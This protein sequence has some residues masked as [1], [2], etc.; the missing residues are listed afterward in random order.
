MEDL[1]Q[2]AHTLFDERPPPS[3]PVPSLDVAGTTS[4][5]TYSSLLSPELP[6]PAEVEAMG[7]TTRHRPGL[8]GGIPTSTQSSFS[9]SPSDAAMESRLTP[10]P[11]P[12]LSPL[13]PSSKTLAEGVETTMQEQVIP[14]AR[15]TKAVET[16]PHST[17]PEVVPVS[18][19]SVAEWRLRQSQL[20]PHP[21]APRIP[22]SPPE[23]VLS[24]TSE[25]PLSSATSLQTA[26]RPF[27]T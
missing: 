9:S 24:S 11:T 8:I 19:T 22:Q 6:Q 13:I 10:S 5:Y 2:N 4:T 18:P 12:L 1:I 16:L 21:E 17:P 3:P 15:G 20:S 25:F 7:S 23:S 27:S 26:M 14:E